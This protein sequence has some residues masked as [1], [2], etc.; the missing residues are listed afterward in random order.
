MTDVVHTLTSINALPNAASRTVCRRSP[1]AAAA[2]A[3]R[4]PRATA[5]THVI[6][7][8]PSDERPRERLVA[9]GVQTLSDSELIAVL[10]GSG[11]HGK[12]AIQLARELLADGMAAL[13]RRDPAELAAVPGIGI[14]KASRILAAGE[15]AR[16]VFCGKP[17]DLPDFDVDLMGRKLVTAYGHH[18]QERLGA[19]FLD[20]RRRIKV[21]REIFVG[22]ANNA[23]V[24]TRD[25]IRQAVVDDAISIVLFH[26]HPSGSSSPSNDDL[27]FTM[28]VKESL[29][30]ADIELLDHLIIGA[31]SYCSMSRQGL[32]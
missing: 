2:R 21:Q 6:S 5:M 27:E 14:A 13:M 28:K 10:L 20:S 16:R 30:F 32:L 23:L 11:M 8:L 17:D 19:V 4:Q 26:N 25:I 22:T 31:H 3:P 29:A 7:D 1:A 24:S 12:N 18:R 15:Y 9:H